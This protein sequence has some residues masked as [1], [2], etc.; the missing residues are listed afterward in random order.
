[1]PQNRDTLTTCKTVQCGQDLAEVVVK[2]FGDVFDGDESFLSA[3]CY[4][5][6]SIQ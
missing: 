2:R 1:M 6:V 3:L 5:V 4:E